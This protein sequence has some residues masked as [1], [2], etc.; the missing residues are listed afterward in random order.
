MYYDYV[1]KRKVLVSVNFLPTKYFDTE[2]KRVLQ[3]S[4][5]FPSENSFLGFQ[6]TN[7]EDRTLGTKRIP[8][9]VTRRWLG[10]H[11]FETIALLNKNVTNK[12]K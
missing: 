2:N 6:T 8:K 7:V 9:W 12:H 3:L 4:I 1:R 5:I 10:L 11:F